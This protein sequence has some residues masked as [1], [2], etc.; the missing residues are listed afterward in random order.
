MLYGVLKK[1]YDR[2]MASDG[3]GTTMTGATQVQWA[4]SKKSVNCYSI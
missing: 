2:G 3:N 4:L 1:V